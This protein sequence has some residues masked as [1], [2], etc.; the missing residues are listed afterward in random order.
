MRVNLTWNVRWFVSWVPCWANVGGGGV[1]SLIC[2]CE[3]GEDEEKG[4]VDNKSGQLIGR[5]RRETFGKERR[6]PREVLNVLTVW[7][8]VNG[9]DLYSEDAGSNLCQVIGC[10]KFVVTL[11]PPPPLSI[12]S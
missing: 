9:H 8:I 1:S 4:H 10:P 7:F 11:S 2:G 12:R 5:I 6:T 3:K